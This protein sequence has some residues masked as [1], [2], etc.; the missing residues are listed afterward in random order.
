VLSIFGNS[1]MTVGKAFQMKLV[2][3]IVC[4][5]VIKAKGGYFEEL[6]IYTLPF[7]SLVSLRNVLV[8]VS[9]KITSN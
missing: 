5:A 7:K 9:I 1:F 8:F 6:Q 4:K 2:E 3:R